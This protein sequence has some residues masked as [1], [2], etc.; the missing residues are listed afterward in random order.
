MLSSRRDRDYELCA[1]SRE[2]E[3]GVKIR[4]QNCM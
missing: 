3:F 4:T 2:S 1:A